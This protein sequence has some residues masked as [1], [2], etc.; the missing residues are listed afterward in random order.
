MYV[1]LAAG[2]S[3]DKLPLVRLRQGFAEVFE[4][5]GAIVS[6]IV[7]NPVLLFLLAAGMVPVGIMIFKR[8]K[9]SAKD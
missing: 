6:G 4:L 2:E 8:L 3:I 5:V 9:R 7:S 1:I